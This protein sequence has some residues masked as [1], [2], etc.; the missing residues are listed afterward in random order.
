[1][2][3]RVPVIAGAAALALAPVPSPAVERFYSDGAYPVFQRWATALSNLVPVALFDLL[4]GAAALGWSGMLVRDLLRWRR[5]GA[6]A[7]RVGTAHTLAG[8]A[9]R[10]FVRTATGAAVVYLAFLACWG[11]NY[12]RVPLVER[13]AFDA[14][15]V[16]PDAAR[17]LARL[18]IAEMNLLHAP[19]HEEGFGT[20]GQ[21]DRQLAEGFARAQA[22]VGSA[23][24]AHPAR[25][26]RTAFDPFF[27][28]AGVEGM[29]DPFFL[30]TLLA[31]GLLPV[32]RPFVIAHEW[33]HLA[34]LADEGEA[35]FV[36]WLTCLRGSR[37]AQYSGWLFLYRE[38]TVV[39]AAQDR[40]AMAERLAPGP[41][42]DLRA[43]AD[44]IRR[45]VNPSVSAAGWRVYDS[46]L[47]AN[48]VDEGT[49][50]Y[51]DVVRIVLGLRGQ[52]YF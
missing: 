5:S 44:R 14:A 52:G 47:K 32:E 10:A 15:A 11:L 50:S 39:L 28:A 45:Q 33:S 42:A 23:H 17:D 20:P 4:V 12:R 29:T 48:R 41:R 34:G 51:A 35:N 6:S 30:E 46:Y 7:A 18:A 16:T 1:M 3:W 19:A 27:N 38:V 24:R 49:D 21:I 31:S 37:A 26:K 36:G 13:L 43:I 22:T 8:V 40:A 9:W 25:P 2:L